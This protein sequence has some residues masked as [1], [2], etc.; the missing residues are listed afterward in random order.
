MKIDQEPRFRQPLFWSKALLSA[1]VGSLTFGFIFACFAKIDE[2]VVAR[3]ELQAIGAERPVKSPISGEIDAIYVNEGDL[4]NE[5][6]ILFEFD[7]KLLEERQKS[8]DIKLINMSEIYKMEYELLD[9]MNSLRKQGVISQKEY[10][11]QKNKVY[12]LDVDLLQNQLEKKDI[13]MK[14]KDSIILSP[15]KGKIFNLIPSSKGY[16]T[17]AGEVLVKIIP[18]GEL[19]AKVFISNSDVGFIRESMNAEVRIDAY[20]FTQFGSIDGELITLGNETITPNEQYSTPHFPAYIRLKNQK[21]TNNGKK[22]YLRSGQSVSVNFLVKD[23]PI[24]SI[25]TDSIEKAFDSLR[26]LRSKNNLK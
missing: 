18:T 21:I 6:Q 20:P 8:I 2:V 25:L 15:V 14:L 7:T 10:L 16:Y 11:Q 13:L 24:I 12:K 19:E 1:M 17:S 9:K 26:S 3:G 23:K 4:V 5:S 22:I